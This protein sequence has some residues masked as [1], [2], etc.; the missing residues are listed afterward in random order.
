MIATSSYSHWAACLPE[1][2]WSE[3]IPAPGVIMCRSEDPAQSPTAI[4]CSFTILPYSVVSNC[5]NVY[6]DGSK[7]SRSRFP[8]PLASCAASIA[9]DQRPTL[10]PTSMAWIRRPGDDML[11]PT[12]GAR[13]R[14]WCADRR[15][16]RDKRAAGQTGPLGQPGVGPSCGMPGPWRWRRFGATLTCCP[17]R[18]LDQGRGYLLSIV[19]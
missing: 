4:R 6:A 17:L 1:G 10:A 18:F 14:R 12:A 2:A 3:L 5:P 8:D 15:G 13:T 11:A 19:A 9:T 16:R 7:A